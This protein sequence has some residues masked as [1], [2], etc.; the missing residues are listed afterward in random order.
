MATTKTI[1]PTESELEILQILWKKGNA[2]VREVHEELLQTKEA[3]Y[4]TTLKLMQIMHE[5]GL[6][7]RDDSI[8]THIYQAA[9]SKEKTQKHL[10]NKMI[11]SL[12]GGSSGELVMQALGNH[13]AS[14]EEL[15]EIQKILDNLKKQ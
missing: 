8:K 11:D 5:K 13:K 14:A 7:K 10:L 1:K 3:G 2:S 4:T 9:V 15:E 12:F 6:V